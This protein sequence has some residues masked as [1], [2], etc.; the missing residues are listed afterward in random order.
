MDERIVVINKLSL[1]KKKDMNKFLYILITLTLCSPSLTGQS[2]FQ[3]TYGG[4]FGDWAYSIKQTMDDGFIIAGA[5]N[6]FTLSWYHDLYLI[7]TDSDGNLVWSKSYGGDEGNET[8]NSVIQTEDEGFIVVGSTLSFGPGGGDVYLIKTNN[9]G[10]T[11]WSKTFGE[12]QNDGAESIIRTFDGCYVIT[13]YTGGG[14]SNS[15]YDILLAKFDITGTV[16]WSK[17]YGGQDDD[18]GKSVQ[19]T[20][21][22]GYIIIG[23]GLGFGSGNWEVYLIKTDENGNILWTKTYGDV[24]ADYSSDVQLTDDGGFILT[25]YYGGSTASEPGSFLIKTDAIGNIAW[26]KLY[27]FTSKAVQKVSDG[28]FVITGII[29]G[30]ACLVKTNSTGDTI[31]TKTYGGSDPD[32]AY[33]VIQLNNG[34][35]AM[36]GSFK[37]YP[38]NYYGDVYLIKTDSNG[39][40]GCF[41]TSYFPSVLD[42]EI[43]FS[44]ATLQMNQTG[45]SASTSTVT[46][47][48][49]NETILCS[50]TE[51]HEHIPNEIALNI[52]PNPSKSET[53]IQSNIYLTNATL[54][55]FN[56]VGERITQKSNISGN[57]INLK[58]DNFKPGIYFIHINEG[59]NVSIKNRMVVLK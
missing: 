29:N 47:N 50:T 6:S 26:S 35:F 13:G 24:N 58:L 1:F 49:G 10:D 8:G 7:K 55:I 11:M 28:G 30:N 4:G 36:T 56:S 33:S 39:Y 16:L 38:I 45:N 21:D 2:I 42:V 32:D 17:R 52:Y 51:I 59:N 53:T 18:Y 23:H 31:W 41:E 48:D 27:G 40:S 19:Q 22:G 43:S 54:V 25:G 14:T 20:S 15:D 12:E 5:T 57:T 37:S 34:G 46:V 3:K 9:E 44:T